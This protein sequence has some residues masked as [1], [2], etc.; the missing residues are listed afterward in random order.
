MIT[1]KANLDTFVWIYK[2]WSPIFLGLIL[3]WPPAFWTCTP[4]YKLIVP[5]L[6]YV[7]NIPDWEKI[8]DVTTL[9]FETMLGHHICNPH[10]FKLHSIWNFNHTIDLHINSI[11]FMWFIFKF[12]HKWSDIDSIQVC[13]YVYSFGPLLCPYK[14]VCNLYVY[15]WP[16][17]IISSKVGTDLHL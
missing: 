6:I 8:T 1:T 12:T 17:I 7:Q 3:P 15:N 2:V 9:R 11:W 4:V 14:M 10:T 16:V 5:P 13:M